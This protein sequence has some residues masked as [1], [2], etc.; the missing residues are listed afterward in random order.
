MPTWIS[1]GPSVLEGIV[2]KRKDTP[3]RFGRFQQ[4][5]GALIVASDAFFS[6]RR[7]HGSGLTIESSGRLGILKLSRPAMKSETGRCRG[8]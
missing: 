1:D 3:Y 4:R 5:D 2:S 8:W 7:S 6:S